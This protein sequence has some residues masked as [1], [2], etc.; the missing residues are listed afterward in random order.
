MFCHFRLLTCHSI[1]GYGIQKLNQCRY[2]T[3]DSCRET[4]LTQP[5]QASLLTSFAE[6]LRTVTHAWA[7]AALTTRTYIHVPIRMRSP[8]ATRNHAF[9]N[10]T[11]AYC[12]RVYIRRR[13]SDST[14]E[15]YDF[16]TDKCRKCAE[17]V[18][19]PTVISCSGPP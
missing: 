5:S 12:V 3:C 16:C 8:T 14:A 6:W 19:C 11:R 15:H 17:N 7:R 18:R 1:S 13:R 4:S 10:C 9:F 2:S